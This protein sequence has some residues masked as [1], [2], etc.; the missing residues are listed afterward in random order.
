VKTANAQALRS[1][2]EVRCGVLI[3]TNDSYLIGS[4]LGPII[5]REGLRSPDDL[6]SALMSEGDI[7]LIWSVV[8]A[9]VSG[10]SWFFR[11]QAPFDRLADSILPALANKRSR[12]IR[13]WSAS[14]AGGQEAYSLAMLAIE[15]QATLDGLP[16]EVYGS[17]ISQSGV[18]KAKSGL[19]S[20]FEVQRGLPIRKLLRHF[21]KQDELWKANGELMAQVRWRRINLLSDL[22]ALGQ[23]D[24]ILC[25]NTLGAFAEAPRRRVLEQLCARLPQDGY[26]VLGA[27]EKADDIGGLFA[28]GGAP[29]L[30]TKDP[31]RQIAAA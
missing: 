11:D 2:V 23:L 4:R 27:E 25:R 16:V 14:C 28:A 6:V 10:E 12:P 19:Y 9:L 13:I 15:S 26:L 29:G 30:Y 7:Q 3:D 18:S 21:I 22:T 8:E 24:V 1:L 5:R 20:Q 17:D 31:E